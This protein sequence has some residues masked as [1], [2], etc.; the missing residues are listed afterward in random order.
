MRRLLGPPRADL[1]T[2][3]EHPTTTTQLTAVTGLALGTIGHHLS[4]LHGAHLVH[5]R[6]AGP[7]VLYYRSGLGDDLIDRKG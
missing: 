4:V 1:L 7:V 2:R 3:L 5:R 6:R